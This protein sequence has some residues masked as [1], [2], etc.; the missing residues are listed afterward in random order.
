MKHNRTLVIIH[1]SN[2]ARMS[3]P[4]GFYCLLESEFWGGE[5]ARWEG[6]GKL[7]KHMVANIQYRFAN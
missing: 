7:N 5:L 4:V 2:V 6:F 3:S 1:L